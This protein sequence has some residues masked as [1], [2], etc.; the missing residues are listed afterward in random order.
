MER[1]AV[2]SDNL[3][4]VVSSSPGRQ[5]EVVVAK[6]MSKRRRTT[7]PSVLCFFSAGADMEVVGIELG[8][9]GRRCL[10]ASRGI[11][12][13]MHWLVV[14]RRV[15]K[16]LAFWRFVRSTSTSSSKPNSHVRSMGTELVGLYTNPIRDALHVGSSSRTLS[17]PRH[18]TSPSSLEIMV[19]S[20]KG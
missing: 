20:C 19:R 15:E 5:R 1:P 12:L 4:L 9:K 16:H 11:R 17:F 10:E 14:G 18:R 6:R 8:R 7:E 3:R 2:G 13:S